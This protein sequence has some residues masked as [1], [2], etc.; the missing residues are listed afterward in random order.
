MHERHPQ[1]NPS[2]SRGCKS[3]VR[4]NNKSFEVQREMRLM[5]P[6]AAAPLGLIHNNAAAVTR[7]TRSRNRLSIPNE[8]CLRVDPVF[9]CGIA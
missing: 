6:Q 3:N 9:F 2:L 5:L 1:R 4:N 7:L 8:Y